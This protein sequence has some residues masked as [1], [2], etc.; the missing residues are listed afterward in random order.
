[1]IALSSFPRIKKSTTATLFV[2]VVVSSFTPY[3]S[4]YGFEFDFKKIERAK[5]YYENQQYEKAADEYR[6]IRTTKE[7]LYNLGNSLYKQQKYQEAIDTYLKVVSNRSDLEH[8]KLHNIGNS[9]VKLQDLQKAKEFYEKA[10]KVQYDE[11]TEQNLEKVKE[12]LEKQ[13][14]KEQKKDKQK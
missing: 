8:K 7:S 3:S 5:N 1:L 9:Y 6:D 12:A 14:Q 13:K 10:L 4:L 2:G 11:Q